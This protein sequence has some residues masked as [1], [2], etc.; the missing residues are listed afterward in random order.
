MLVSSISCLQRDIARVSPQ[1][2][3]VFG[4]VETQ[5]AVDKVDLLFM[6]DNSRSMGDKQDYLVKAVPDLLSRL[7]T[8][9]CLDASG[10][11]NGL[12]SD[13]AGNCAQGTAEFR[14]VHDMHIG[15]VSS[16]L[17]SLGGD[18]CKVAPDTSGTPP[19][20]PN[21]QDDDGQ[22][23]N[24]SQIAH[25]S[26]SGFLDWFPSAAGGTPPPPGGPP[27]VAN[28]S[29]LVSDFQGLVQSLGERGCGIEAQLESWYRLLVQP[30]PYAS[31]VV[32]GQQQTAQLQGFDAVVL[33]QRHDFLRPDSLLAIIDLSDENDSA[34]DV[35]AY[36]GSNVA[37]YHM[38][39][40][41]TGPYRATSACATNPADPACTSCDNTA[42]ASDPACL[43]NARYSWGGSTA[44]EAPGT[45]N[46]RHVRMKQNFGIDSQY[47]IDRYVQGLTSTMVPDRTG[48]Y[49]QGAQTY[50]GNANCSNPIFSQDL[51][52]GTDLDPAVLCNLKRGPRTPDLVYF[53][54][55][56][57]VPHELLQVDPTNPD[58]PQKDT[59]SADDWTKIIGNPRAYDTTGTDPRMVETYKVRPYYRAD[60]R[61]RAP[62]PWRRLAPAPLPPTRTA[63]IARTRRRPARPDTTGSS[64]IRTTRPSRSPRRRI[65]RCASCGSRSSSRRRGSCP[66]S[67]PSTRNRP[68]ATFRPIRCTAIGRR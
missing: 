17:G 31:I 50:Q 20:A 62:F 8:P 23:L 40:L 44:G 22:L 42:A 24:R 10:N 5:S 57:G 54:H 32:D 65:P 37:G 66:R 38:M 58:S 45:A 49:P 4:K 60:S 14:P 16:S 9:S 18:A 3:T 12:V 63:A 61:S 6:I 33:K 64:A 28:A 52:D 43:P 51:P 56:G 35:R 55:I 36:P 30:D 19:P 48:E 34:I 13:S 39:E 59:L 26:P 25:A 11:P 15:I 53:A 7:L 29:T 27:A 21:G 1:T 2:N 68:T 41:Q 46:I 47:P 67:A